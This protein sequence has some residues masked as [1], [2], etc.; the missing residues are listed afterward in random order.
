MAS[1]LYVNGKIFTGTGP[2]DFASAF[3]ITNGA[4]DWV[5]D[6]AD[7][8]DG[9]A[10]DLGGAT[11]LPGL[12][13]VHTH[14]AFMATLVGSVSL[15][16]P[17]VTSLG[18]LLAR[19]REHPN[20]GR[21]DGSWVEGFGYDDAKYADGHPTRAAL[22]TVSV[23]QAVVARRSDGHTAVVNSRAL[24]FAASRATPRTRRARG[25]SATSVAISPEC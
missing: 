2:E 1:R 15:L 11:V 22:D 13:D 20:L 6:T 24:E 7:A 25:T 23:D 9:D 21:H 19:L 8:R 12:I 5:G 10:V 16:P 17:G 14:P 18:Q 3:R 4:F